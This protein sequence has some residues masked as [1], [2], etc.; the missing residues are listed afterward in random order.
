MAHFAELDE[1]NVVK[2]TIVVH[3]NE[4]LDENGNES[5]QKGI[6][7]CE[8]LLG[9]RWVQTS[10]NGNFR[11][12]LATPGSVYNEEKDIF[13]YPQPFQSWTLNENNDWVAPVQQPYWFSTWNEDTLSWSIP[14]KPF[15]S[16][17]M[18]EETGRW[19]APV[20]KPEGPYRWDEPTL[21][22]IEVVLPA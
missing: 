9:G 6:Y 21:S 12:Q 4:L 3:N 14:P 19:K 15:P 2:Q 13:I 17:S 1:N 10:Y 18:D 8:Q 11:K 5:E 20:D 22:W 7:F 16:W